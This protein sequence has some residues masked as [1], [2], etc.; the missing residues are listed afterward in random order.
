MSASRTVGAVILSGVVAL[1]AGSSELAIG[2][3]S[4]ASLDQV[5]AV[6]DTTATLPFAATDLEVRYVQEDGAASGHVRVELTPELRPLSA[7]EARSAAQQGF[8]KALG[9]SGLGDQLSEITVVVRLM[10]RSHPDPDA[11]EQVIRY[12]RKGGREWS[13]LPQD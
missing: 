11:A 2:A 7:M 12:L 6:T 10:P 13:V 9:E 5:A 8:L 3:V 4:D 1:A